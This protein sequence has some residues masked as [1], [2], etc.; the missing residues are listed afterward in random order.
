MLKKILKWLSIITV[1]MSLLICCGPSKKITTNDNVYSGK[2]Y[3]T[4]ERIYTPVQVDSMITAD[5]LAA[6]EHWIKTDMLSQKG[7]LSQYMF[8]KSL[9]ADNEL[10]YI[11]TKPVYDDNYKCI[12]RITDK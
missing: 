4:L 1:S 2:M 6:L 8:I 12:K 5:T 9:S 10:I 7:K 11:L 3:Y